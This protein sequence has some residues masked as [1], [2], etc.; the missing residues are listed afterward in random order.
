MGLIG[1]LK[2]MFTQRPAEAS[3][4]KPRPAPSKPNSARLAGQL[5][6]EFSDEVP[7]GVLEAR[8]AAEALNPKTMARVLDRLRSGPIETA[9]PQRRTIRA[10]SLEIIDLTS[11]PS[12]RTRVK[13]S[14]Y[15]VTDAERRKY[16]GTEYFLVREPE[17]PTDPRA[18][19]VYG[20]GHRVGYLSQARAA[21]T[22]PLLAELQGDA[23]QVSGTGTTANS[24]VLWVDVP[25]VGSLRN[26]RDR[27]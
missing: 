24:I 11:L 1:R 26:L 15:S 2:R 22:S 9:D 5:L 10:S 6:L 27:R 4:G 12:V 21:S 13:G 16:G 3:V 18:V 7:D 25:T 14:A 19:A 23:F 8:A 17:N 20:S